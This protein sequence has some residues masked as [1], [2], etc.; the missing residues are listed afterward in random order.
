MRPYAFR[1]VMRNGYY[2]HVTTFMAPSIRATTM[3]VNENKSTNPAANIMRIENAYQIQMAVPG[4]PKDQI[5]IEIKD[6]QLIISATNPNQETA[7]KYVRQEFDF[8][9]FRR[10]FSLHKNADTEKLTA[11]FDNGI[12]TIVIPD[13]QPEVRKIDIQ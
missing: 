13:K 11:S 1:P 12:L 2:P 6:D 4:I 7:N 9:G 3:R 5:Q 8:R 10:N